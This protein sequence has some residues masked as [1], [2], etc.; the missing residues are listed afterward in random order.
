MSIFQFDKMSCVKNKTNELPSDSF[1][2][3]CN[4]L[5]EIDMIQ[6]KEEYLQL[7]QNLE[8][9][10]LVQNGQATFIQIIIIFM[11]TTFQV[12]SVLVLIVKLTMKVYILYNQSVNYLN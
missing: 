3:I 10:N 4:W 9:I 7:C 2:A 11:K 6:L 8:S 12:L 5:P 1:K